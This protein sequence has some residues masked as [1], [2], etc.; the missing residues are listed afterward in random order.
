VY[1]DAAK[2][3]YSYTPTLVAGTHY[4]DIDLSDG[5]YLMPYALY[6]IPPGSLTVSRAT[7]TLTDAGETLV[8]K[9]LSTLLGRAITNNERLATTATKN[10]SS[11]VKSHHELSGKSLTNCKRL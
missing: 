11:A 5:S 4:T 6:T 10:F 8:K 1:W 2:T 3:S 7:G 9:G